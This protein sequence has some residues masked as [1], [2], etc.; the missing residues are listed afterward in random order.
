LARSSSGARRD[1]E[2]ESELGEEVKM[3]KKIVG[4]VLVLGV[5]ICASAKMDEEWISLFDGK[6]LDGWKAS[7]NK[8]TFSV[9]DNV[10]KV[11]GDR[12]HL[13]YV[14]PVEE[15]NFKNFRFKC[16]VMTT[17]GSNSGIYFHTV[18]R[19]NGWPGKGYEAQVN[20]SHTD[21]KRTGG[22]YNVKD[23]LIDSPAKDDEWFDYE[24]IVIG[25]RIMT[26]IN[27]AVAVDYTEPEDVKRIGRRLDSG[28]FCFQ[29]H[30]PK[31][32][33]Y[34]KDVMVMPLPDNAKWHKVMDENAEKKKGSDAKDVSRS[35]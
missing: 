10:I 27:G 24:I 34:Y 19:E 26:K 7:E 14:G 21:P 13:Y 12:S 2:A 33:V 28:T 16:K 9:E 15:G 31:S 32:L 8:E 6:S 25:K 35:K 1:D 20:N 18:F 4:C 23:I 30:D 11:H 29:G 3:V 17:P 22:L 5:A